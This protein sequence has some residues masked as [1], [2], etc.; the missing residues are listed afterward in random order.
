LTTLLIQ[1]HLIAP[2]TGIQP[3]TLKASRPTQEVR[4]KK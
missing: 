3:L 4:I 1:C 2:I